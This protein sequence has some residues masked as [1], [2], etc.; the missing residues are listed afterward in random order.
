MMRNIAKTRTWI[1]V[2]AA[3]S[4]LCP[5]PERLEMLANRGSTATRTERTGSVC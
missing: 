4:K 1:R 3:L 2:L 5:A